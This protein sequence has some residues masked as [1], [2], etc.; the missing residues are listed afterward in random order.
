[1]SR[2]DSRP[3]GLCDTS[4]V[5]S[6]WGRVA[7][8]TEGEEV[9]GESGGGGDV[10][11]A[12]RGLREGRAALQDRLPHLPDWNRGARALEESTRGASATDPSSSW[13]RKQMGPAADAPLPRPRWTSG[14]K[15]GGAEGACSRW[16]DL[17]PILNGDA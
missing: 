9:R 16:T 1:N 2:E 11:R 8:T 6:P 7:I 15:A 13:R 17:R 10:S 14:A 3:F 5:P 12:R 4:D